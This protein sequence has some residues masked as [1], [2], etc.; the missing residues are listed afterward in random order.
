MPSHDSG[1]DENSPESLL[2][3]NIAFFDIVERILLEDR[4]YPMEQVK[5]MILLWSGGQSTSAYTPPLAVKRR[6]SKEKTEAPNLTS[7]PHWK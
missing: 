7:H 4:L 6:T 5:D 2:I 3:R 1:Y